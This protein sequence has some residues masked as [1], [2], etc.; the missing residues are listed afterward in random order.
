MMPFSRTGMAFVLVVDENNAD[1]VL[2]PLPFAFQI[3]PFRV[4]ILMQQHEMVQASSLEVEFTDS[5]FSRQ[6]RRVF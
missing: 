6:S 5:Y 1:R 4:M 2:T 3:R